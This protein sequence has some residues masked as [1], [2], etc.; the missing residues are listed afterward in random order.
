M[1]PEATN[2][3]KTPKELYRDSKKLTIPN[4]LTCFRIVLIPVFVW[5]YSFKMDYKTAAIVLII[6]GITDILDGMIARGFNMMSDLGKLLDPVADK[7][8]QAATVICLSGRYPLMFVIFLLMLGK[9]L[10]AFW[11]SYQVVKA[12]GVVQSAQWHGKV[13]TF[14]LYLMMM[15]HVF[16]FEIPNG[17][18][19]F[20]IFTCIGMLILSGILYEHRN[21]VLMR[22]KIAE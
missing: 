18:S 19:N 21:Q 6:S 4:I 16:W 2:Q 13:S 3:K 1:R 17:V 20:M 12:T 8:T 14:L 10:H 5:L 22:E 15:T 7:L 9:E 11:S